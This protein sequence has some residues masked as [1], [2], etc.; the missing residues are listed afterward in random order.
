MRHAFSL[1][2]LSIVL[3]IL[4]LLTGG[5]LT[6]QSLIRAAELRSVT[7]EF[8]R[9]QTA[10]LSFRDKYFAMPGDM[11]NATAFWGTAATCPGVRATAAAGVC[12][13]NGDGVLRNDSPQSHEVFGAWEHLGSAGLVEGTYTGNTYDT[14]TATSNASMIG[15]NIPASRMGNAGWSFYHFTPRPISDTG[16][17]D[18][19]YGYFFF[20]GATTGT[21]VSYN[22]VL[23]PEEAWNIDT[24]IDDGMPATGK[25]LSL[26]SQAGNCSDLAASSTVSL[27]ASKYLLTNTGSVCSLMMR[28]GI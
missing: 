12:N 13:G 26:E 6:G 4:G 19:P 23:T 10:A 21:N 11:P 15:T 1:V 25:V 17:F 27:T 28:M 9:Y 18:G 5:I 7:T 24:K 16:Y 20:F 14:G 22:P 8:Q 3:V 2:E